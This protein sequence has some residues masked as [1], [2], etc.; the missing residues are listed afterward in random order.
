MSRV[1]GVGTR[2]HAIRLLPA[3]RSLVAARTKR[4]LT[5]APDDASEQPGDL[6]RRAGETLRMFVV[7]CEAA[8]V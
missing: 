8:S 5:R 1:K 2:T 7:R 4:A 3:G 6:C